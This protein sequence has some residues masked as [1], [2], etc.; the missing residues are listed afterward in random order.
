MHRTKTPTALLIVLAGALSGCATPL[1]AG[2][3]LGE[4]GLAASLFSTAATGKGVG[5]HAMDVATGKNCRIVEGMAR[6]D[7]T[8]CEAEDSPAVEDD[9]EGLASLDGDATQTRHHVGASPPP[10]GGRDG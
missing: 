3:T 10:R 9:W 7:R 8:I 2:L 5:E 1:F 4:L 6:D